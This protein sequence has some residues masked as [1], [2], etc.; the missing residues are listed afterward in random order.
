MIQRTL[1]STGMISK[2][3]GSRHLFVRLF[4]PLSFIPDKNMRPVCRPNV[5]L[6]SLIDYVPWWPHTLEGILRQGCG[7]HTG[8]PWSG[9]GRCWSL[10]SVSASCASN[11]THYDDLPNWRA[12]VWWVHVLPHRLYRESSWR[13]QMLA[14]TLTSGDMQVVAEVGE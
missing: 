11:E 7:Y 8:T 12:Q 13:K 1:R 5:R 2:L 9:Y 6:Y 10:D 3:H 4:D 14:S